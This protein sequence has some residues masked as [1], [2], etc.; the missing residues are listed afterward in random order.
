[1]AARKMA[2]NLVKSRYELE[3][4]VRLEER[5]HTEEV[6]RKNNTHAAKAT[7]AWGGGHLSGLTDSRFGE[8]APCHGTAPRISP[9]FLKHFKVIKKHKEQRENISDKTKRRGSGEPEFYSL[10][11]FL[12]ML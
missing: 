1:M 7:C 11:T 9:S 5:C 10:L 12:S 3:R 8:G 6:C 2:L 4:A